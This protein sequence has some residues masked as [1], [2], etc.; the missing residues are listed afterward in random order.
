M[1]IADDLLDSRAERVVLLPE[2]MGAEEAD[3]LAAT[4]PLRR[5]GTPDDVALAMG[6]LLDATF[7]TGEVLLVDGG[8]HV[9]R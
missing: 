9:R 3:R 2:A 4:T 1:G 6:Y 8:R 5:H 7:V